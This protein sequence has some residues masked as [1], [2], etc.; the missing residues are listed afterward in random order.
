MNRVSQ[1][2]KILD[3]LKAGHR[4]TVLTALELFGCYALSQRCG[5]LRK[6][7]HPVES[8]MIELPNG[9][10]VKEYRIEFQLTGE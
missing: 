6:Q 3:H 2:T 1:S 8:E 5:D 7:G 10:H 9:K 4:L